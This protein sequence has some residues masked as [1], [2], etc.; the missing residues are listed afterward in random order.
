M[1][2]GW[3]YGEWHSALSTQYNNI[4]NKSLQFHFIAYS[5]AQMCAFLAPSTALLSPFP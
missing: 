1:G 4:N 3:E 5:R 2:N